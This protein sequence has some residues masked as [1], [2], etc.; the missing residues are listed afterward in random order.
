MRCA[1]LALLLLTSIIVNAYELS[2]HQALPLIVLLN[3]AMIVA[4]YVFDSF[5]AM[6]QRLRRDID[7]GEGLTDLHKHE[8]IK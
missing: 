6:V 4:L 7:I 1:F 8:I 3:V 2:N 5:V